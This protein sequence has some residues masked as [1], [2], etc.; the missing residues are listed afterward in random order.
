MDRAGA[1]P[2]RQEAA[3]NAQID[4]AAHRRAVTRLI[5]DHRL[6]APVSAKPKT[7]VRIAPVGAGIVEQQADAVE[8]ADGMLGR[9]LAAR[10]GRLVGSMPG[11]PTSASRMPSGSRKDSTVSPKRLRGCSWATPCSTSRCVQ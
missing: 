10:P 11:R 1:L 6:L 4:D 3:G 7:S 5:A 8:A 9:N 2:R